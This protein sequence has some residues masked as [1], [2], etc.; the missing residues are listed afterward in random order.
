M[1]TQLIGPTYQI[2]FRLR[3]RSGF[4]FISPSINFILSIH[5]IKSSELKNYS[6]GGTTYNRRDMRLHFR[7]NTLACSDLNAKFNRIL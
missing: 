2:G 4:G 6:C 7:M 3:M 1:T 5:E